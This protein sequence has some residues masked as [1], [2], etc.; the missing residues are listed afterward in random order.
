MKKDNADGGLRGAAQRRCFGHALSRLTQTC[1]PHARREGA[2][3]SPPLSG[4][5]DPPPASTND[6]TEHLHTR[7]L[8]RRVARVAAQAR[9]HGASRDRLAVSDPGHMT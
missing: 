1:V 2:S 4:A 9:P 8:G 7:L 3:P 6:S 5:T